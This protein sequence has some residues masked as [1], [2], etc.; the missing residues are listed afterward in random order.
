MYTSAKQIGFILFALLLLANCTPKANTQNIDKLLY[1]ATFYT[2][3]D[4][5]PTAAAVAIHQ[6]K[7]V[8]IGNKDELLKQFTPD[9]TEDLKGAFVY[10]GFY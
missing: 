8:G 9:T 4:S 1:N 5:L 7:I 3:V 6:G 2:L 10:P